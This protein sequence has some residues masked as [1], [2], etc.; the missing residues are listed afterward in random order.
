M[1]Q[2]QKDLDLHGPKPPATFPPLKWYKVT[3]PFPRTDV[4][5]EAEYYVL[6]DGALRFSTTRAGSDG[7]P[8]GIETVRL[9]ASGAW[10]DLEPLS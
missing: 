5:V 2:S 6:V 4:I 7:R 8:G 9:F 1:T 3:L 10:L